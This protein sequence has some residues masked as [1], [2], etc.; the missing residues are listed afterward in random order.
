MASIER[1]M[2]ILSYARYR[3]CTPD[4][5]PPT[6]NTPSQGVSIENLGSILRSS[7]RLEL[8]EQPPLLAGFYAVSQ[9]CEELYV[10]R[11]L[12]A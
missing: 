1:V 11:T 6:K 5:A 3:A 8:P 4:V 12:A 10:C 9:G 7:L 2:P